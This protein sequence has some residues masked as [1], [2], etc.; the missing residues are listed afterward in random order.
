[1]MILPP[2]L[3]VVVQSLILRLAIPAARPVHTP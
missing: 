1:M 3:A 2:A